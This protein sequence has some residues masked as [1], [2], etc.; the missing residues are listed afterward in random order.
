MRVAGV[1]EWITAIVHAVQN[2][3]KSKIRK[4]GLYSNEFGLKAG[5]YQGSVLSPLL[6]II[7]LETMTKEFRTRYPWEFLYAD[8]LKLIA[9]SLYR[10]VEK[11]EMSKISLKSK[12]LSVSKGKAKV[13]LW[14]RGLDMMKTS[15]KY[16]CGVCKK[17]TG[18]IQFTVKLN[19]AL[20]LKRRLLMSLASC[21]ADALV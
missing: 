2:E 5:V 11:L 16:P 12:E 20:E 7:V 17:R 8:D 21:A 13:M 10:L 15:G 1:P 9:E 4:N 19:T 14:G 18:G 6:F 3:A